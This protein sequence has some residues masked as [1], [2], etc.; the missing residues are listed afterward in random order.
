LEQNDSSREKYAGCAESDA[1][2]FET[3][4]CHPEHA[5]ERQ[6][7]DCMCD[8]LSAM[9]LEEPAHGL[10]EV[11]AN[12]FGKT[13]TGVRHSRRREASACPWELSF[14]LTRMKLQNMQH[15]N[16]RL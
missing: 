1:A 12:K 16:D 4:E 3:T 5:H 11:I 10:A 7:A 6:G 2:D 15:F 14:V 13:F 9:E 8:R